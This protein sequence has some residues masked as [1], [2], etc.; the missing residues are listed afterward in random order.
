MFSL[1]ED[2][3]TRTGKEIPI[4]NVRTER[5]MLKFIL[6]S[7]GPGTYK[8]YA[9]VKGEKG[10]WTFWKGQINDDGYLF[11]NKEYNKSEVVKLERELS[12][13][14]EE[15]KE[16]I[17]DELNFVKDIEKDIAKEKKYGL[18]GYLVPSGKRGVYH[19]WDEEQLPQEQVDE[20]KKT[21][22]KDISEMTMEEINAF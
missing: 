6:D 1:D 5:Q 10:L 15:E 12:K 14:D 21:K 17:L 22:R 16:M 20:V 13:A 18:R 19:A 4:L 2:N 3:F 7:F 11:E 8:L 9:S